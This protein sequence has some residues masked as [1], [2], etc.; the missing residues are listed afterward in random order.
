MAYEPLLKIATPDQGAPKRFTDVGDAVAHPAD[1]STPMRT[2]FPVRTRNLPATRCEDGAPGDT[3][4]RAFY[5]RLRI[6]TEDLIRA[7]TSRL[8]FGPLW[9][10]TALMLQRITAPTT[11]LSHTFNTC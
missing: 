10:S 2:T 5:L 8:S 9:P 3:R 11:A 7:P 4:F 6:T 1:A